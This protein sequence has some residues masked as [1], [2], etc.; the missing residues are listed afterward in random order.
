MVKPLK[1][2]MGDPLNLTSGRTLKVDSQKEISFYPKRFG[3][4]GLPG[5]PNLKSKEVYLSLGS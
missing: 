3:N 2:L 5:V 4:I 1:S